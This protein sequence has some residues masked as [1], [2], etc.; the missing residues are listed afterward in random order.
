MKSS[1]GGKLPIAAEIFSL[2]NYSLLLA[3]RA[4]LLPPTEA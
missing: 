3:I 2:L 1:N 4:I